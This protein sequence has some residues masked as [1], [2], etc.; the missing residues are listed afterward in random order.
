MGALSYLLLSGSLGR[1]P[2]DR[3]RRTK[4][5]ALRI[6]AAKI[7]FQNSIPGVQR[8]PSGRANQKAEFTTDAGF[9]SVKYAP[10]PVVFIKSPRRA[11]FSADRHLAVLANNRNIQSFFLPLDNPDPGSADIQ[12]AIMLY[13]ANY[14]A[15]P[16][17][18]AFFQ[19]YFPALF[20]RDPDSSRLVRPNSEGS[21]D[22]KIFTIILP[23]RQISYG[24]GNKP[25]GNTDRFP[26]PSRKPNGVPFLT[27]PRRPQFRDTSPVR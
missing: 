9:L 10:G 8:D 1:Q 16:A 7:A 4:L 13:G 21:F 6:A 14:F 25:L 27:E 24:T 26:G 15:R 22:S 12:F 23:L 11:V 18:R 19:I 5:H 2:F 3:P 20:H 17:P